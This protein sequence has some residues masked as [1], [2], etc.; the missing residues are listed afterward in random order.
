MLE[1]DEA[2]DD[3]GLS[4]KQPV[5]FYFLTKVFPEGPTPVT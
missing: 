4:G 2:A 3:G 5:L 1:H